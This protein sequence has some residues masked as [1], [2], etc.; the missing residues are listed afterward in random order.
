MMK[1]WSELSVTGILNGMTCNIIRIRANLLLVD[2]GHKGQ[3]RTE[4]KSLKKFKKKI[5]FSEIQQSHTNHRFR[6]LMTFNLFPVLP[7]TVFDLS[8][9]RIVYIYI[10][11]YIYIYCNCLG[12]RDEAPILWLFG[13][14]GYEVLFVWT[15]WW[16]SPASDIDGSTVVLGPLIS[17]PPRY[18][19]GD[20]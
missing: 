7:M 18:C 16:P 13:A 17:F 12:P 1:W 19:K 8:E 4:R 11:I 3:P 20:G 6:T 9:K 10:Y 5:F 2:L 14:G 15:T